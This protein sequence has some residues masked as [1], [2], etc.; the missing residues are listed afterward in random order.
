MQ[1]GL[2]QYQVEL[3]MALGSRPA[4]QKVVQHAR[5]TIVPAR[6]Q[7]GDSCADDWRIENE[8][9]PRGGTP[10]DICTCGA[11][12][13]VGCCQSGTSPF[14]RSNRRGNRCKRYHFHWWLVA[15]LHKGRAGCISQCI[16]RPLLLMEDWELPSRR[17]SKGIGGCQ[18]LPSISSSFPLHCSE[19]L[20]HH[21]GKGRAL[22]V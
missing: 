21:C 15:H 12:N 8:A 1:P 7:K 11:C 3:Q 9:T 14:K 6:A 10:R 20:H 16:L 19:A 18:R 13:A 22:P 5:D 17:R 2:C 4:C